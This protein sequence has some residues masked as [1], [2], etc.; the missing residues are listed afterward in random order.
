[1]QPYAAD[2]AVLI[3]SYKPDG[4]LAPYIQSLRDAGLGKIVIVDDGSGEDYCALF[5]AIPQDDVVHIL[6]YMP[7]QGKGVALKRG[8][9][10]LWEHCAQCN[11]II[12]A[13]SDGQHTTED[14]LRMSES[15]HHNGEGLLLGSRDFS[16]S[17]VPFKSRMGNRITSVVFMV[18]YGKW[19]SD[20][21]TGL[22]GFARPL[23]PRMMEI[24]GE[25]YEYEMNVLIACAASKLNI[26]SLNIETV[27]ENNNE[28]SHFRAVRD[29]MRI[30]GVI[31]SGFFRFMGA[32][33]ICFGVDYGLYLLLNNFFKS[34]APELEYEFPLLIIKILARIALATILARLVSGVLNFFLNKKFVFGSRDRLS[35]TFPRYLCVF[36]LIMLLSAGL[37]SSLHLWTGWSENAVKAPVDIALFFLSYELQQKWVFGQNKGKRA[38]GK[39]KKVSS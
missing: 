2:T 23:L 20:T 24:R 16:Q 29:S 9:A 25:R 28:G 35:H 3:P 7:N 17:H 26:R 36:L 4:K 6:H 11:Y 37:T 10:Y 19:V 1:M 18:L 34:Y 33:I 8:M 30:Y 32:S 15:L 13:D 31:F 21:Q 12:T 38:S 27:Y 39:G 22:R 14:V 5:E